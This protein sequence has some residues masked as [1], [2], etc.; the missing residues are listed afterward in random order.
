RPSESSMERPFIEHNIEA[1]RMAY[2]LSDVED[3]EFDWSGDMEAEDLGDHGA[4]LRNVRLWDP[5]IVATSFQIEQENKGLYSITDVDVDR[6]DLPDGDTQVMVAARDLAP[7]EEETSWENEH[8]AYTHGSG[9][10]ASAANAKTSSG[11]PDLL[12]DL[13]ELDESRVYFGEQKAGYV[14]VN[15]EVGEID[16]RT[17][18][19]T[20]RG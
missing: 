2:G 16:G 5:S 15:T 9:V 17:G 13:A 8:L 20:S 6:Y 1:T 12:P 10:V 18:E 3:A 14:I 11:E 19:S 7:Q 4:S